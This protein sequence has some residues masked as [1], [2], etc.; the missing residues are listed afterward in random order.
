M[1]PYKGLL[2]STTIYIVLGCLPMGI[3]FLLLPVFSEKLSEAEY[4]ILTL[5][6]LFVGIA[7]ILVGLGL[8]G[9]FSRYYYQYYKQ[10]KLVDSLLST[11][12]L[13]IGLI[14]TVLGVILHF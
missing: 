11:L 5:A 9:A 6:S 7:T 14:A 10:P 4:G 8:E 3:N 12:I 2:K 13:A 1:S